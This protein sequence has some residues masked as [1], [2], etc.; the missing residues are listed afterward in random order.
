M[1]FDGDHVDGGC[2]DIAKN[3]GEIAAD[4]KLCA[5][6]V[7]LFGAVVYTDASVGGVA[8]AIGRDLIALDEDNCVGA[9]ADAWDALC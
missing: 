2:A 1:E 8:A 7:V 3:V 6:G 4:C 5:V 9:F